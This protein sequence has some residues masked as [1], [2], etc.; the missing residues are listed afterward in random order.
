M[1]LW[2]F[3]TILLSG[4]LFP[5]AAATAEP[6]RAD[7]VALTTEA[8]LIV[9]AEVT[10]STRLSEKLSPGLAPGFRRFLIEAEISNVLIAPGF[11]PK[12]IEYLVDIGADPRGKTPRLKGL[13]VLL[14]LAPGGREAQF[15]LVRPWAQV[16]WSTERDA[17]VRA[18]AAEAVASPDVR[19]MEISGLGQA[20]HV[21]GSLPGESESQIFIQTKS[22]DPMSLVVLS[23]PGQPKAFSVATGDIIDDAAAGVKDGSLLWY[24]LACGLPRS[25]PASSTSTLDS[26]T[27]ASATADYRF[28]LD[29]LGPCDRA[30]SE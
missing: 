21:P 27:A 5:F 9:R 30:Y 3:F 15:Q 24:Q 19:D 26:E 4:T 14:F 10:K 6:G 16:D 23:R 25:L 2:A 18:V 11:V 1:R 22:G 20:F 7:L 12:N 17:Y 28:V 13:P 8:P 29:S